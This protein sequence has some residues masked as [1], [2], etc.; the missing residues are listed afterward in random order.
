MAILLF[1]STIP[2]GALDFQ[3][4]RHSIGRLLYIR[5]QSRYMPM[6]ETE[7]GWTDTRTGHRTN[8]FCI[9]IKRS[10]SPRNCFLDLNRRT[11]RA[12]TSKTACKTKRDLPSKYEQLDFNLNTALF[13]F[14]SVLHQFYCNFVLALSLCQPAF[15]FAFERSSVCPARAFAS[16]R[17]HNICGKIPQ[18]RT[19]KMPMLVEREIFDI[20]INF[21]LSTA[22]EN[23]KKKM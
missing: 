15:R 23:Q 7:Y 4:H 3:P 2:V 22:I 14:T 17:M 1:V 9:R 21:Y 16:C 6:H 20:R 18:R 8:N 19:T 12:R 13:C 10:E 5:K 11:R